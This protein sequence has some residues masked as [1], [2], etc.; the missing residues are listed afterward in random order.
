MSFT[1]L[2]HP[3]AAPVDPTGIPGL[4]DVLRGGLPR[5]QLYLLEGS[6]G[7]GKTTLGLQFLLEGV[8]RGER[9]LWCTLSETEAQL[10]ATA[11]S[12]G[13]DLAGVTIVNLTQGG[14]PTGMPDAGYSFFSPADI[15][16]NDIAKA[17]LDLIKR[18][19][20]RRVVFDPFSDVRLLARDPLRY[21]RQVLQLREHLARLEATVLLIRSRVSSRRRIRRPKVWSMASSVYTST[22]RST[23]G[24]AGD[25]ASTSCAASTTARGSTTSC[26]APAGWLSFRG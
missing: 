24:P 15:E 10:D 21:R 17:I 9:V 20:P 12:H 4:D 11:R 13:W 14:N 22:R 1:T 8:R 19:R 18:E 26:C 3:D 16:L 6:A 7:A 5:G 23:D 2:A 25:C